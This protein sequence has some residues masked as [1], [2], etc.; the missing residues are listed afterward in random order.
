[1]YSEIMHVLVFNVNVY[2]GGLMAC[3]PIAL[4]NKRS[5]RQT[6]LVNAEIRGR[7]VS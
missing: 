5:W 3:V 1:M 2:F 4:V 7:D 6:W